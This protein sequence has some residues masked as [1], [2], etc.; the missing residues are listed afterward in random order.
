MLC[1]D[2]VILGA[3]KLLV[4]SITLDT[5]GCELGEDGSIKGSVNCTLEAVLAGNVPAVLF[6]IAVV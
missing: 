3:G 5:G 4:K 1:T 2:G 6:A